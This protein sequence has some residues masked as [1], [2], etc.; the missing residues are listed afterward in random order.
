MTNPLL[1]LHTAYRY[2]RRKLFCWHIRT[3]VKR[4]QRRLQRQT[5]L[6]AMKTSA[7]IDHG[8]QQSDQYMDSLR[9]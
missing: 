6:P 4:L 5:R 7:F 8:R 2:W 1:Y 3:G 9:K